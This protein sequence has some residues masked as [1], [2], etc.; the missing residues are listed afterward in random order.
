MIRYVIRRVLALIPVILVVSFILF[1]LVDQMPGTL[2][3]SLVAFEH[4]GGAN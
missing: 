2:V 4:D 3:D 1:A